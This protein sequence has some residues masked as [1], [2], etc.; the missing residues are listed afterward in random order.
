MDDILELTQ[1]ADSDGFV[2][3]EC[4]YCGSVFKLDAEDVNDDD[5]PIMDLFCPYC[6]LSGEMNRFISSEA[7]EAIEAMVQNHLADIVNKEFGK[8]TREINRAG[9]LIH[10][11]FSPLK[12]QHVKEVKDNDT[13]ESIFTCDACVKKVKVVPNAG[14]SKAFC[15]Y[16]GVDL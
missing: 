6:G 3:Y 16:C 1:F 8:M 11:E 2:T 9:G 4:P 12:K 13:V 10:M 15:P 5:F 7:Q 14:L